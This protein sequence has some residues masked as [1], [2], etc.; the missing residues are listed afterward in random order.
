MKWKNNLADDLEWS[1][2]GVTDELVSDHGDYEV[3][4]ATAPV[5][6]GEA[7]KFLRLEVEQ[8]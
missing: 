8:E 4:R 5:L 6:P 7:R 2:V 1:G 3:R